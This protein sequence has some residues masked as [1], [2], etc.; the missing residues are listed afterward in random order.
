MLMKALRG[1]G[2]L[3]AVVVL[4]SSAVARAAYLEGIL[5]EEPMPWPGRLARCIVG[6][7]TGGAW[8]APAVGDVT[9]D[10]ITD[11]VVGSA[12]GDV[13][14]Y[15]G[16]SD[17][18]FGP[19][20]LLL[21]GDLPEAVPALEP[22][23]PCLIGSTRDL[24][25][26]RG[27][28]LV[29]YRRTADGFAPGREI[30]GRDRRPLAELL[31]RAGGSAPTGLAALD[32]DELIVADGAGR[33]WRGT[34]EGPER[35]GELSP[36]RDIH[37]G[38]LAFPP[39]VSLAVGDLSG[40]G[41]KDLIIG[42][43]G[44]LYLCTLSG[45]QASAP[46][47]LAREI[48]NEEGVVA[49]RL[50][51]AVERP[52]MLLVGTRWGFLLRCRVEKHRLAAVETIQ[53]REVPLDCGLCAAPTA[54]DWER[55]GRLDLVVAGADGLLRLFVRRP[56][57]FFER[58]DILSDDA[59][60]IR[61]PKVEGYAVGFPAFADLN[62]DGRQELLVGCADGRI[63]LFRNEGRLVA[64]DAL[65]VGGEEVL[66]DGIP[67]PEAVD[68]DADGDTDL[69][70]GVQPRPKSDGGEV[71]EGALSPI[72][73]LENQGA[74][75]AWC[76]YEKVVPIDMAARWEGVDGDGSYISPWQFRLHG[77]PGRDVLALVL[78][79]T[80]VYVFGLTT[81]A[82]AYPRVVAEADAG[83]LRPWRVRGP[84]WSL[85]FFGDEIAVGLGP[86]GFVSMAKMPG[87]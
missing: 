37:G 60:P 70:V 12:Y 81:L 86:Y 42:A 61:L 20:R 33:L 80:G 50:A 6:P 69:I 8:A 35:V 5:C 53:A 71:S 66:C 27:G 72:R 28:R 56:D 55:D 73:F 59:G 47:E 84:V 76:K 1:S 64:A 40:D 29:R 7:A 31:A 79:S 77:R 16:R 44:T 2:F 46:E 34:L 15:E 4:C 43:A 30:T 19:P 25:V 58:P 75:G 52:G 39:P 17:G 13:M 87:R 36:F 82:P 32:G 14:L 48:R 11:L 78:A 45:G 41:R 51:P 83:L 3:A 10:A 54:L 18:V 21:V 62:G 65:G 67:V 26:L 9:G 68:W 74:R 22:A 85:C 24:L 23:V 57:G 38:H 49:E 63:L